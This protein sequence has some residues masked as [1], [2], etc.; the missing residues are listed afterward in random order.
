MRGIETLPITLI[1]V[2][3]LILIV[4]SVAFVQINFFLN[5]NEKR[6]FKEGLASIVQEI[7]QLKSTGNSGSFSSKSIKIPQ[8]YSI[9]LDI[10]SNVITGAMTDE[11]YN[12]TLSQ[13]PINLTAFGSGSAVIR[14]G[15]TTLGGG[16]DY[17]LLFYYGSLPDNQFRNYMMTFE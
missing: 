4:A 9:V 17:T 13:L 16:S 6:E 5:F 1:A 8:G 15:T 11:I 7:K 14:N 10:D 2:S 12:I 3:I